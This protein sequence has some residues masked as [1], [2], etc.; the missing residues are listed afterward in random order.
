M[1][2]EQIHLV[3]GRLAEAALRNTLADIGKSYEF[4][5]TVQIMPITVAALMSPQ[6]I[7]RHI[8]I[9]DGT[10]R[11]ILP[12]YCRGDLSVLTDSLSIPVEHGP[13]DLRQLSR[14]LTGKQQ[15]VDLS[16]YQIEIIA[17]INHVPALSVS[18][19][20]AI[21][22]QYQLDGA[23]FI[24][25]GC[26][27]GQTCAEI[28]DYVL[29][30]K[31]LGIRVSI[32]S[33]N[34]DEI[35]L[36]TAAGAELVLS[37]NSSNVHAAADWGCEVVAIPDDPADLNSIETTI[38]ILDQAGVAF[39]IDPI[40]EP[41]GL[42]FADSL[43][44]YHTARERWPDAEMMM[45]I[46][47]LSE[48]SDVDSAGV[49]L[50]LLGIC[51][52]LKIHSVL[53]TQV[54]NWATSSVKECDIARRLVSYACSNSVPPKN[55]STELVVLRDRLLPKFSPQQISDLAASIKDHNYRILIDEDK[56]HLLGS[57]KQFMDTDPFAVFDALME[58]GPK[59]VDA[60]HAFYLGYEMC[61]AMTAIALGKNYT[62]DEALDWGHLTVSEKNRH[63][64]SKRYRG[65]S[66][67]G[68]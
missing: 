50:I 30:I 43:M 28:A 35:A 29:A 3:T 25:V 49:N 57:G 10:Q 11:V 7:A 67:S 32:D 22:K 19:A 5:Y 47:N 64:L 41:I 16:D 52:E 9:P 45:G 58:S 4:K 56:I 53:T 24:D 1:K 62:Q 23:D 26:I 55:L 15:E 27:P 31:D 17:E 6:W 66:K 12:G 39:R 21:A 54:I 38:E 20:V 18:D 14:F 48:L 13:K 44:R 33:L 2:S 65:E 34:I 59:N 68:E 36:A 60:S 63:R 46:G 61:K 40:L 8:Q 51:Q 37:V 42:G